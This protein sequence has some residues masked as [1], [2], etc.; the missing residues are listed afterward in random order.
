MSRTDNP[1]A[2]RRQNMDITL[3]CLSCGGQLATKWNCM[4][5]YPVEC[6]L[7]CPRCGTEHLW[8]RDKVLCT[9]QEY[10]DRVNRCY[11]L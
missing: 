3:V 4:T 6:V 10:R 5:E 8:L 9:A 7:E 11:A 2:Y 1:A